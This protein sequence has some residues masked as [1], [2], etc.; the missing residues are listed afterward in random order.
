[1]STITKSSAPVGDGNIADFGLGNDGDVT[2]EEIC[3]LFVLKLLLV[4]SKPIPLPPTIVGER[5]D[6]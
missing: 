4:P 2:D 1:M 3:L 6:D 5:G